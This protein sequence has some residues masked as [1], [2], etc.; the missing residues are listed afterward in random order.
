MERQTIDLP[1]DLRV[2]IR[3]ATLL[4]GIRRNRLRAELLQNELDED[5]RVLGVI[6]ADLVSVSEVEG[7]EGWPSLDVLAALPEETVEPWLD[8]VQTA[9]LHWYPATE[10]DIADAAPFDGGSANG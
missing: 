1:G 6:Y 8:K 2:T 10:A 7:L 3:P 9:N 4:D 5:R